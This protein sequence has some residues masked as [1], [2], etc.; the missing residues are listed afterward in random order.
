[1]KKKYD[2]SNVKLDDYEQSIDLAIDYKKMK[3]PT[4]ER[5]KELKMA[6]SATLKA[7]KD[8]RANIRINGNDMLVLRQKAQEAGLPYQTFIAHIMHLYLTNQL[9][10]LNEVKKMVE[11]GVFSGERVR[12]TDRN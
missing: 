9:V 2:P 6:A 7:L 3:K 4:P 8:T 12:K 5:Q 10:N 1:M 11:V